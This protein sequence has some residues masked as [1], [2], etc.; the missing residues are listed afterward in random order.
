MIK[1]DGTMMDA[2]NARRYCS[3]A[4]FAI[5]AIQMTDFILNKSLG[6]LEIPI[7]DYVAH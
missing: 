4:T 3:Q 6:R 2:N 1:S 5:R 7:E